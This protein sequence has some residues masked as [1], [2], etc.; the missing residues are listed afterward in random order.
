MKGY[1]SSPK[2]AY[3]VSRDCGCTHRCRM[4]LDE[5]E[6]V[7]RSAA[8]DA[9]A[10]GTTAADSATPADVICTKRRPSGRLLFPYVLLGQAFTSECVG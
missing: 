3:V 9:T 10:A 2:H 6:E 4:V 1:S 7:G 8:P 5:G